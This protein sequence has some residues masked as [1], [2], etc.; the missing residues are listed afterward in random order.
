MLSAT[1]EEGSGETTKSVK[2]GSYTFESVSTLLAEQAQLLA[3]ERM[4][5]G[6]SLPNFMP[7]QA[8]ANNLTSPRAEVVNIQ[9][10]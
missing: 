6:T 1:L 7:E 4:S 9:R 10:R 2:N 5:V 8:R 3:Q